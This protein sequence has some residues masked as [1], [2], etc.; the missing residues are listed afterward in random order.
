[1]HDKAALEGVLS[2]VLALC[3]LELIRF[4][5]GGSPRQPSLMVYVDRVGG[6]TVGE[7]VDAAK[8]LRRAIAA[9]FG[10]VR[11]FAVSVSSPGTDRPLGT[12]RDF[13]LI[14]GRRVAVRI[15]GEADDGESEIVGTVLRADSEAVVVE[16]DADGSERG[17][18]YSRIRT[19]KMRLPYE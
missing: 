8:A 14:L 15:E 12:Q 6:V 17:V 3:G 9:H 11:P 18:P 5:V 16:S 19:A 4:T 2:P 10:S 13:A 7:C 1:M